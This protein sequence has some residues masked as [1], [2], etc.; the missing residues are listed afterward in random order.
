MTQIPYDQRLA[1]RLVRPFKNTPLHPNHLTTISLLFGLASAWTFAF[2]QPT[3]WSLAAVFF[4]LAVFMDHTDGELARQSGKVSQFGHNYDF[5]VGGFNY[6][7]LFIAIGIGLWRETH[8]TSALVLGFAA[9]LSNPII[10]TL[11]MIIDRDHGSDAV[12]HPYFSGFNVEDFIYLIGPITWFFGV[13]IFFI[14]YG[15][16]TL[17]Y[18]SWTIFE[19]RKWQTQASLS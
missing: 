13:K 1:A 8:A 19:Y 14:A 11:R 17:G 2:T 18:L 5:L 10:M 16:G 12:R 6:T 15:L 4:M 9:G 7:I 3:Y